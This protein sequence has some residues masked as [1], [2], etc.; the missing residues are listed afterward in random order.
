MVLR[1]EVE[2]VPFQLADLD[3]S[4]VRRETGEAHPVVAEELAIGVVELPAMPVPFEHDRLTVC[5][6]GERALGQH[7]GVR[8]ESHGPAL[9]V[10]VA[11]LGQ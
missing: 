10:H 9:V 3:Q 5:A 6:M 1:A 4:P 11:L 2:R 7:A 8:A